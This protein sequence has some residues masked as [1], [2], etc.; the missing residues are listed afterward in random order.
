[1]SWPPPAPPQFLASERSEPIPGMDLSVCPWLPD[2]I[3]STSDMLCM[4]DRLDSMLV[5]EK[6]RGASTGLAATMGV[7]VKARATTAAFAGLETVPNLMMT[8]RT[9]LNST[10][11]VLDEYWK[12]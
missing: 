1:M 3:D 6:V 10:R 11:E 5:R 8:L 2:I 12:K 4:P 7:V 9:G